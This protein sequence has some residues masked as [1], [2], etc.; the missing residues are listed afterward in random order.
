[1]GKLLHNPFSNIICPACNKKTILDPDADKGPMLPPTGKD[2]D[3]ASQWLN[4][5]S[6]SSCNTIYE[7][8]VKVE[9]VNW[10]PDWDVAYYWKYPYNQRINEVKLE[11]LTL[12]E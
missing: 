8:N 3:Y 4:S 5:V 12:S 9:K 6:C 1:M 10:A 11:H 2:Y 7:L